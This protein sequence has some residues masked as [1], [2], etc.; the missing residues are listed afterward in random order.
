MPGN[1]SSGPLTVLFRLP[2]PLDMHTTCSSASFRSVSHVTSMRPSLTILFQIT[3]FAPSSNITTRTLPVF[4]LCFYT[5]RFT[6]N[7]IYCSSH[8]I[9]GLGRSPG[10]GIGY[11]LQYSW[12]SLVAQLVKNPPAMQETCLGSIPGLGRSPGEWNGCPLQYSGLENSTDCIVHG[13]TRSRTGLSD[14]HFHCIIM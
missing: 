4:S 13:V 3:A 14:F 12:A 9:P 10:E 5:A 1:S 7:L 6:T 8:C 2:F 11:P